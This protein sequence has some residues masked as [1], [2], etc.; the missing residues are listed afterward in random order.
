MDRLIR[1]AVWGMVTGVILALGAV[2]L[3]GNYHPPGAM[4]YGAGANP[5]IWAAIARLKAGRAS[6]R[7]L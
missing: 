6:Q 5:S 4:T 1:C 2:V 3:M 7:A